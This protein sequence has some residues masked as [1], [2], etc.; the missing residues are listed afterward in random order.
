VRSSNRAVIQF[1]GHL[2]YHIDDVI[3]LGKR[4]IKDQ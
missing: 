4:L 1:Y 3:S 2:G